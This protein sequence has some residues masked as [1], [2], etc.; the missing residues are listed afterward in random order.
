MR[1][2]MPPVRP[3]DRVLSGGEGTP[4]ATTTYT[5]IIEK[6]CDLYIA[7]CLEPDVA[8]APRST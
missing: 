2:R 4:M 1:R 6:E 8:R 5:A 3:V 7:F